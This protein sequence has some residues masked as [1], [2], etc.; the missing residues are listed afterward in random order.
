[1]VRVG[2]FLKDLFFSFAQPEGQP[3]SRRHMAA[4][5]KDTLPVAAEKI[6]LDL[7][8]R[9]FTL[10]ISRARLKS[11]LPLS[12]PVNYQPFP[13]SYLPSEKTRMLDPAPTNATVN[14]AGFIHSF[15]LAE[16][17]NVSSQ[18]SEINQRL[19]ALEAHSQ[20]EQK[21]H[22]SPFLSPHPG[23]VIESSMNSE[24][25]ASFQ[26]PESILPKIDLSFYAAQ[27]LNDVLMAPHLH[28]LA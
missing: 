23:V 28:I 25:R 20:T 22:K 16:M 8:Y 5:E 3:D 2:S 4:S 15:V 7:R 6:A 13:E 10:S 19:K 9:D 21:N 26:P 17:K 27:P 12:S 24:D 14:D 11:P 18:L 1:M